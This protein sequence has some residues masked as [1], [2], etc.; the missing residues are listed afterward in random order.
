MTITPE[1]QEFIRTRNQTVFLEM[2]M[3]IQGDITI[4]ES[5]AIKWGKPEK[6]EKY[7]LLRVEDVDVYIPDELPVIPLCIVRRSFLGF[8][9]L[10]VEGWALA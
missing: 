1:A 3:I 6:I 9:W 4:R 2:P 10:A 7:L 8:K 5:P